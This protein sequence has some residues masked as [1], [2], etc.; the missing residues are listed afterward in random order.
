MK[1]KPSVLSKSLSFSD[2]V[3]YK[4]LKIQIRFSFGVRPLAHA[5]LL[6]RSHSIWGQDF[7]ST[8]TGEAVVDAVMLVLGA[9][10]VVLHRD[11]VLT[12]FFRQIASCY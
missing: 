8:H 2:F 11:P 6:V 7:Q 3:P 12:S 10:E 9:P 4:M 5:L 1:N